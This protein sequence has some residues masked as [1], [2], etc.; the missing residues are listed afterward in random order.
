MSYQALKTIPELQDKMPSER[1]KLVK[2]AY[3]RDR[4]LSALNLLHALTAFICL[5]ISIYLT[6]G[7]LGYRS[8]FRSL[9]PYFLLVGLAS[10]FLTRFLIYPRIARALHQLPQADSQNHE[11]A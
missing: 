6:E 11:E 7:I 3:S 2:E 5:P 1:N 4:S 9:P 10:F 8:L